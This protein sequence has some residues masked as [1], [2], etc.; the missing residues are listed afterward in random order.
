LLIRYYTLCHLLFQKLPHFALLPFCPCTIVSFCPCC[1]AARRPLSTLGFRR[2]YNW[3]IPVWSML[4]PLKT[5][6]V[7]VLLPPTEP[8]RYVCAAGHGP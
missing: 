1:P 7:A 5:R 6:Q 4:S 2:G 3:I 8:C